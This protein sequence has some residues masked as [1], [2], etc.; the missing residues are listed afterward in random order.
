MRATVLMWRTARRAAII[1]FPLL[2]IC[3]IAPAQ[4]VRSTDAPTAGTWM[5]QLGSFSAEQNA[6][7]LAERAETFGFTASVSTVTTNGRPIFR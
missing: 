2:G 4:D 7:Q 1:A 3:T 5:V 6:R